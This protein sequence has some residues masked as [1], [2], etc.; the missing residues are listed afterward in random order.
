MGLDILMTE[1]N[2]EE[3]KSQSHWLI[4][5]WLSKHVTKLVM[6][7]IGKYSPPLCG[8]I[9]HMAMGRVVILL[10]KKGQKLIGNNIYSTK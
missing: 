6:N 4:C 3:V 8:T 7:G 10:F 9:S 1:E 2:I 5:H